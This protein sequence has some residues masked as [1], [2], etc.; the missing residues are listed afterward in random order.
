MSVSVCLCAVCICVCVGVCVV[1]KSG[2]ITDTTCL[3]VTAGV[4]QTHRSGEL[5]PEFIPQSV[6]AP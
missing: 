4:F 3:F 6:I 2:R 5:T 1:I